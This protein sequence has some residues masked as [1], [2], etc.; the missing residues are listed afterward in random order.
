MRWSNG[1]FVVDPALGLRERFYAK[2]HLVP[3]G[4]YV[5]LRGWLPFLDKIVPV[6]DDFAPGRDAAPLLVRAD[7]RPLEVGALVCYEDVFPA[8]ARD[9][10]RAGAQLLFVA[11]NNGWFGERAM[12]HQHAAHSVVRAVETRRPV[13]RA[14]NGGWSGWIDEY[15]L[16]RGRLIDDPLSIYHR[17]S[18]VFEIDRDRR[19]VGRESFY[20]RWGDWLVA[21]SALFVAV[22][23]WLLRPR[24]TL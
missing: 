1:V 11:T 15:G 22:A 8:L 3:F 17:G 20:V 16:I 5:P 23:A 10:V 21:L 14:G 2:R 6:G 9:A 19:W 4:E 18:T 7:G 12:A 13:L 24:R